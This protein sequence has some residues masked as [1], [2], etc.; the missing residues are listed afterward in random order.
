[1]TPPP[2]LTATISAPSSAPPTQPSPS[3]PLCHGLILTDPPASL[4]PDGI[5]QFKSATSF[6]ELLPSVHF[7]STSTAAGAR[8]FRSWDHLR[9]SICWCGRRDARRRGRR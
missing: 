4:A 2:H 6:L 8:R 7:L 3:D 9:Y 5:K 1:M